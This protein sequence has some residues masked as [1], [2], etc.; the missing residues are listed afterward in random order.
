MSKTNQGCN[1]TICERF[2]TV[3]R[4]SEC[5]T[6]QDVEDACEESGADLFD[7]LISA[8]KLPVLA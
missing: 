2:H 3:V 8:R 1:H 5:V 7:V 4:S 6:L